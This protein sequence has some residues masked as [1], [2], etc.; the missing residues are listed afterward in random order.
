MRR[1][2]PQQVSQL[3]TYLVNLQGTCIPGQWE[4]TRLQ[5][6]LQIFRRTYKSLE[7]LT[8]LHKN[9]QFLGRIYNSSWRLTSA[10]RELTNLCENKQVFMR[11]WILHKELKFLLKTYKSSWE[12]TGLL[13]NYPVFIRNYTSYLELTR[14]I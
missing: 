11:V 10:T 1:P 7:E 8:S 13:E 2:N 6:N 4:L 14:L 9:L 3:Q 5:E 12:F